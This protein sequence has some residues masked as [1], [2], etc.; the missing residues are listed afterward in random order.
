MTDAATAHVDNSPESG[1]AIVTFKNASSANEY[2]RGFSDCK[3]NERKNVKKVQ[4]DKS[5]RCTTKAGLALDIGKEK[6]I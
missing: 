6:S 1:F 5:R 2:K 4:G 3:F